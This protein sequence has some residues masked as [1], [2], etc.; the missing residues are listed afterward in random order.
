MLK[1]F[2]EQC[3]PAGK[4]I[5]TDCTKTEVSTGRVFCPAKCADS[6]DRVW[7]SSFYTA[8]SSLCKAAVH[9]GVLKAG[10]SGFVNIKNAQKCKGYFGTSSN[11]ITTE[12]FGNYETSFTFVPGKCNI[13]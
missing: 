2:L 1:F 13:Q 11:G 6:P 4:F 9:A 5:D 12:S 8:D 3:P 7:G 10:E